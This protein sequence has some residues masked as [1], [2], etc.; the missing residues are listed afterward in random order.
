MPS[1]KNIQHPKTAKAWSRVLVSDASQPKLHG[2]RSDHPN[3]APAETPEENPARIVRRPPAELLSNVAH[4]VNGGSLDYILRTGY[5][6]NKEDIEIDVYYCQVG[7]PYSS[8]E[9]A[10]FHVG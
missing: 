9:Q 1:T 4:L 8:K 3:T 10:N 7:M 5:D 2:I 6:N